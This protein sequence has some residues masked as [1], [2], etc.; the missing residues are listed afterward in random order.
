MPESSKTIVRIADTKALF[1]PHSSLFT[2][3]SPSLLTFFI[4]FACLL[5]NQA[6]AA[7]QLP[8]LTGRVVDNANMLDEQEEQRLTA[9][10]KKHEDATTNQV[11]VV[12]VPDL[13]GND[14][15]DYSYQL[16]HHWGVG[17]DVD[18]GVL[19][20]VAKKER[21]MHIEAGLGLE[22]TL[23]D[24]ICANIIDATIMPRFKR[25]RFGAGIEDGVTG[26]IDTLDGKYQM[27]KVHPM[28]TP[29][30]ET[31][32]MFILLSVMGFATDLIPSGSSF[33][34]RKKTPG[35]YY[36]WRDSWFS[37]GRRGGGGAMSGW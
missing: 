20:V 5:P 13:G 34:L 37:S 4:L 15:E 17:Q 23:T 10:L 25:G 36:H 32:V 24:A 30:E 2:F 31:I 9:L 33:S 14:I 35:R 21:K 12:T 28:L 29:I 6:N 1:T 22:D 19:L 7:I 16:L 3:F 27:K 18:N 8:E 11:V 26:I